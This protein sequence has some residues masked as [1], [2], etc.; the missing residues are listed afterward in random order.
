M[1]NRFVFI[2][3]FLISLTS[4]G[5]DFSAWKSKVYNHLDNRSELLKDIRKA[6]PFIKKEAHYRNDLLALDD[7]LAAREM[8][9]ERRL[10]LDTLVSHGQRSGLSKP[11]LAK[12][13]MRLAKASYNIDQGQRAASI[14]NKILEAEYKLQPLTRIEC[15]M[16]LGNLELSFQLPERAIIKYQRALNELNPKIEKQ[17]PL[18]R[19][20]IY[21]NMGLS[22]SMLRNVDSTIFYHQRAYNIRKRENSTY[23]M[24]QSLNNIGT[25]YYGVQMYDSALVYFERGL[26]FRSI[27]PEATESSLAESWTNIGKTHFRIGNLEKAKELLEKSLEYCRRV[28]NLEIMRRNFEIL[29]ELYAAEGNLQKAYDALSN[30]YLF[31]DSLYGLEE[32]KDLLRSSYKQELREQA[33]SDSLNRDAN[34]KIFEEKSRRESVIKYGL[35]LALAGLILILGLLLRNYRNK[36]RSNKQISIQK[37]SLEEKNE[38][39]IG[40]ITYAKRL[41]DAILPSDQSLSGQ[42]PD[43]FVW[44]QPKDIV[45][46]DFYWMH[47]SDDQTFFAVSDCTGHGVPGALVSIVCSNALNR[48]TKEFG[49]TETGAILDKTTELVLESFS[50]S[51][52]NVND[53]MDISLIRLCKRNVQFSGAYNGL[54]I[55]TEHPDIIIDQLNP[56]QFR[57]IKG[58]KRS[59][60]EIKANRQPVGFYEN[61]VPFDS[62]NLELNSGDCL[63]LLT[64]GFGD[65]FGG[66]ENKKYKTSQLKRF[67]LESSGLSTQEQRSMIAAE[68]ELWKGDNEQVDDI[69]IVGIRVN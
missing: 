15:L 59:L 36:V 37:D 57:A 10:L 29:H 28:S 4:F 34:Q 35:A 31:R 69:C 20:S 11:V 54:W 24:G 16:I 14:L 53:G 47:A 62:V 44:Y 8:H 52:E 40:S 63:Y 6:G 39:I 12:Y 51:E 42:L 65:Q 41:Q 30:Y 19:S 38:E 45:A 21:N 32:T 13:M 18:I 66:S 33:L 56:S 61:R 49:L 9:F 46:G 67:L 23:A 22:Y 17:K 25:M 26:H 50:E 3:S 7:T 55:A 68:F 64:D 27:S 5:Q 60:I 58:D 43:Q 2:L 48:A 1:S